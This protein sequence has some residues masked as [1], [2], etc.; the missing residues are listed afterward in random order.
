[1]ACGCNAAMQ[2]QRVKTGCAMP[3]GFIVVPSTL[4][5][6]NSKGDF[7]MVTAPKLATT[8]ASGI[9]SSIARTGTKLAGSLVLWLR[10]RNTRHALR[11]LSD[12]ELEDIG[13]TRA[14]IPL[15][16]RQGDP[17]QRLP[18]D[19]VLI[20]ALGSLIERIESWRDRRR[21]QLQVYRELAAYSDR[22]LSELGL[23]RRDIPKIART[24]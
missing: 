24:S 9:E 11:Q 22:D 21:H 6:S 18:G 13:T 17:W 16:A 2:Y 14:G 15:F 19:A 7:P 4:A 20:V 23:A 12:R 8:Y 10:R 1:M 5:P 3:S